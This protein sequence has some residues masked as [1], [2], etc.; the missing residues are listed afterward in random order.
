MG[1]EK[2]M[3]AMYSVKQKHNPH[4]AYMVE[5]YADN[6]AYRAHTESAQYRAVLKAAP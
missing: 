5:I 1:G 6:A 3:L 4:T 2:G